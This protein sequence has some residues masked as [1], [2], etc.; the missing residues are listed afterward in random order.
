LGFDFGLTYI[1]NTSCEAYMQCILCIN[2]VAMCFMSLSSCGC[3]NLSASSGGGL[4]SLE[5]CHH[6]PAGNSHMEFCVE[7]ASYPVAHLLGKK[8]SV[9]RYRKGTGWCSSNLFSIFPS[10]PA[11]IRY[12]SASQIRICR[13]LLRNRLIYAFFLPLVMSA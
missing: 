9:R 1:L 8:I 3:S 4:L 12:F 11:V 2:A 6:Q 10:V 13:D 5:D 7:G